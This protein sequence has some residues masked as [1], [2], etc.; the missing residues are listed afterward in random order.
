LLDELQWSIPRNRIC[1]NGHGNT[2]GYADRHTDD[3]AHGHTDCDADRH[4][5][6]HTDCDLADDQV[7]NDSC[8]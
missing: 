2:S 7:S 5:D 4:P 3:Y 6:G 8:P 1:F